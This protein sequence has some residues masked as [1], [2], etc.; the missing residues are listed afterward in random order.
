MNHK[1]QFIISFGGL[2][3]GNHR[4]NFEIDDQFFEPLDYS[5]IRHGKLSVELLLDRQSQL[6]HFKFDIKG[7]VEVTCDRCLGQ[8]SIPVNGSNVLFVKFG[9][10]YSEESHELVVI[11]E[12][13]TQ[14]DLKHYVYE[15][16]T[17]LVPYRHVHPGDDNS[18]TGCDPAVIRKLKDLSSNHK[19]DP[20]WDDLKK[21]KSNK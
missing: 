13:Q 2:K 17:L 19:P 5:E 16:I 9:K 18:A 15:F 1:R 3:I 14:I 7:S 21:L 8:F 4:F 10:E 20:R 11:P 6:L 12:T